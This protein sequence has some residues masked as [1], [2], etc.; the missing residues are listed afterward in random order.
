MP[1]PPGVGSEN[2]ANPM[3]QVLVGAQNANLPYVDI[4]DSTHDVPWDPSSPIFQ[5]IERVTVA[6][7]VAC[8]AAFQDTF[9]ALLEEQAT[10]QRITNADYAKTFLGLSQLSMQSAVQF[11]LGKDQAFWMA[12]KTQA[13]AVTARNQNER[14]RMEIMLL[15]AQFAKTK[16]ELANSDSQFGVT[17]LQRTGVLPSQVVLTEKQTLMVHEQMEAQRAQTL[18]TRQDGQSRASSVTLPDGSTEPRMAGLLGVQNYLYRQQI[19][20]YREDGKVKAGKLFADLWMTMKTMNDGIQPSDWFRPPAPGQTTPL[21]S[22][23][24]SIRNIA[25][26]N[27]TDPWTP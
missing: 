7:V 17:E 24:K 14:T 20:S 10:K 4:W 22:V 2:L 23:F 11:M 27:T 12:V 16:Q 21:D 26:G 6:E 5:P 13:D 15:R 25:N 1:T 19:M 3:F 18:D 9:K 8:A